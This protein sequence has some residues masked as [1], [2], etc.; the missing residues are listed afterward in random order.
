MFEQNSQAMMND[1][2]SGRD[3]P[4]HH[5]LGLYSKMHKDATEK[6]EIGTSK[7]SLDGNEIKIYINKCEEKIDEQQQ[8]QEEGS[9]K[10]ESPHKE[11]MQH[12]DYDKGSLND[13][14]ESRDEESNKQHILEEQQLLDVNVADKDAGR[15]DAFENE[16]CSD[17]KALEGLNTADKEADR[18]DDFENEDC[19]DL[20]ALEDEVDGTVTD[21][22]QVVVDTILFGMSTPSTTKSLD[23]GDSNKMT[24]SQWDL[25]NRQIPPDFPDAYVRKLEASKA[26]A[27]AK[28]KRKK[29]RILRSPYILKYGSASKD[30]DDYDKEKKLKYDFDGYTI[31]Q[32]LPNKFIIDYSQWIAVGLLKIHSAK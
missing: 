18:E 19:S 22:I 11:D 10:Q 5:V 15:E 20:K 17:L 13:M 14:E 8:S 12:K 25:P 26:K 30:A 29:S 7:S 4:V 6:G 32:D 31:N 9:K 24:E 27:P 16:D 1:D 21:S 23:V 3:H 2:T 28:Q